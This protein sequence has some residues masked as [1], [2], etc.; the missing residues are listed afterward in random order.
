VNSAIRIG[1]LYE[2]TIHTAIGGRGN[3]R[4]ASVLCH[5][6]P[7]WAAHLA[8]DSRSTAAAGIRRD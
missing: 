8:K 5:G 6:E 7:G 2:K 3:S 1:N 4:E